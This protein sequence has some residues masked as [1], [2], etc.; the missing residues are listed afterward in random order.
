MTGHPKLVMLIRFC[1]EWTTS[2]FFHQIRPIR[3]K[4]LQALAICDSKRKQVCYDRKIVEKVFLS[5][6]FFLVF[7]LVIAMKAK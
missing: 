3:L 5:P 2:Q 4:S 1:E 7:F 6:A